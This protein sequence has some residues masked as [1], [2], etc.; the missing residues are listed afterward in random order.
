VANVTVT[1]TTSGGFL[2]VWPADLAQPLASSLNWPAGATVGN[3]VTVPVSASGQISIYNSAGATEVIVDV[4]GYVASAASGTAGL[5]EPLAPSRICDTRASAVSGITDQCTGKTLGAASTLTVQVTGEGGV[6]STG[7]SAVVANVTVTDTTS[8]GFLTI[9]PVGQPE[10]LASSLN[11][12][13]GATVGNLVTVPVS[14]S[15]QISIYNSAGASDVVVDVE[16]WFT[17]GSNPG[18]TGGSVTP[19]PPSRICD[20]RA[21]AVSGITDQCTGKT[22][23][24]ANTLTVQVGG[25]GGVPS[26]GMSAVVAHVAVTDT[27][28]AGF[29]TVWPTGQSQP[30]A[31]SLNWPAGATVGNLVTVPVSAS[32]GISIYNSSGT[33][34]VIVDVVGYMTSGGGLSWSATSL[35]TSHNSVSCVSPTFC[36]DAISGG[37]ISTWNGSSWSAPQAIYADP[38][39]WQSADGPMPIS[40]VS[41]SFCVVAA[42]TDAFI[43]NGSTW[44]AP[45]V[46]DSGS[47]YFISLS[48]GSTT[49][50]VVVDFEGN[51]MTWNGSTWSAPL[52]VDSSNSPDSV[53]CASASFCVVVDQEGNALTWDGSTWSALE[54]IDPDNDIDSVS[55]L[56][57]SFCMAA[58]YQGNALIWSGSSW[59]A[60]QFIDPGST[61][62]KYN[63]DP[64]S[65]SCVTA[66]YCVGVDI[67]QTV[68]WNGS[69]WSDPVPV[70]PTGYLES[71]S[72]TSTTFCGATDFE[73]NAFIGEG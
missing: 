61:Y 56:S 30:L 12:A 46:V 66:T 7:V 53:S 10:P 35:G 38:T 73:G 40:C 14:A 68:T 22:L 62:H 26:T 50:C 29:L 9:W 51:A 17:D 28:S 3:L 24:A 70:E 34:D 19:V 44:S 33:T 27:T 49:L 31:S 65:I 4:D 15:G 64:D 45:L 5:S 71:L 58:D 36:M 2:T 43:W 52:D 41:T 13:A 47:N 1:D 32:G 57:A 25:E 21:S 59:S 69:S 16:S 42:S 8:A 39:F 23:G 6:P 20:T 72:C 55:C 63:D 60:P 48:C 67:N 37:D 18:A 54:S 11:W